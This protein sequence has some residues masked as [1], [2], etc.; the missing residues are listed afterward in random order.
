MLIICHQ[1]LEEILGLDQKIRVLSSV[2][3]NFSSVKTEEDL[4]GPPGGPCPNPGGG[5]PP[6]PATAQL[7]L[8]GSRYVRF[9]VR[10]P[11]GGGPPRP[12]NGGAPGNPPG[13]PPPTPAAGPPKPIGNPLPAGLLIPGPVASA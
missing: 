12:P 11:P 2:V 6:N 4:R 8:T 10:G 5:G 7:A 1:N 3:S 13:K 9:H